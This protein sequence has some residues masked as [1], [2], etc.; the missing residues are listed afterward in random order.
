MDACFQ[1]RLQIWRRKGVETVGVGFGGAVPAIEAIIEEQ[2]HFVDRIIGRH[3]QGVQQVNL[4]VGT[5]FGQRDL[6][7]GNDNRFAQILQHERQRRGGKCHRVGAVQDHKAV[8]LVVMGF[9]IFGDML[10]VFRRHI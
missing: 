9:D 1:Q 4:P 2:R 7:P 6:R 5:Q 3:V 8:V 10:P